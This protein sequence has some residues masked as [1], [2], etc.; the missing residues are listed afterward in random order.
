MRCPTLS[1]LPE[2]IEGKLGFP[3]TEASPQL[4]DRNPDGLE[5]AKISIVTPNYNYGQFIEETI[6][7]VLLQGYPNLEY[8]IIDGGST[9][10]SVEIIRKYEPWLTF[11]VSEKDRGQSNAI[12]KGFEHTSGFIRGYLNSDD[13]FLSGALEKVG[14]LANNYLNKPIIILGDCVIGRSPQEV[15]FVWISEIPDTLQK[16]I[17]RLGIFPQPATLWTQP[18]NKV[19]RYF[20]ESLC[21]CMDYDLW[22]QLLTDDYVPIKLDT[23]LAFFRDH[24]LSKSATV[25]AEY[26]TVELSII[27]LLLLPQLKS[28]EEKLDINRISQKR[29]RHYLRAEIEKLYT[30]Q[31]AWQALRGLINIG[32]ADLSF[33]LEKPTLGLVRKILFSLCGQ[34]TN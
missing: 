27:P 24:N 6:R 1:E 34:K 25:V 33:L 28:F 5:W 23:E 16:A 19:I 17:N 20:K 30:Y 14:L 12:N 31:G 26:Q 9:D 13:L 11:W 18:N 2:P 29:S 10:N 7:S 21:C 15:D 8:I 3:W 4:H 32:C 22:C